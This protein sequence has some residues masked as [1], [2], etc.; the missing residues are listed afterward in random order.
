MASAGLLR[1][2]AVTAGIVRVQHTAAGISTVDHSINST[3]LNR[4]DLA[5]LRL[6]LHQV[7]LQCVESEDRLQIVQFTRH[8]HC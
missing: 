2:C 8:V 7:A 5:L 3:N 4:A 6:P 1:P